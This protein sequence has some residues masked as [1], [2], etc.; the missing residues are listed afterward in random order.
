MAQVS[1]LISSSHSFSPIFSTSNLKHQTRHPCMAFP[2]HLQYPTNFGNSDVFYKFS[3]KNFRLQV[4]GGHLANKLA[5]KFSAS[6]NSFEK[7]EEEKAVLPSSW[8]ESVVPLKAR[9]YAYLIRLDKPIGTWLVAWPCLWSLAFAAN[10]GTL[11]DLGMLAFFF[12][13]SFMTRNIGCTINDFF[14]KDFDAQVERTKRRPVAS[15][16]ITDSQALCFLAIQLLIGYVTFLP[17][18][19]LSRLLWVS[20]LPLIFTYPLMKRITYW[21]QAHLG[22]AINWGALYSWAAVKGSLD[23]TIVFPLF[24]AC[25]FWTLEYDTIYA[26]QD[27]EDDVKVGVKSTALLFGDSTKIW[28][29][30][31][32]VAS[33]SSLL[34]A[35]INS[36]I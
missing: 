12:L 28:T 27:K 18:N 13:V 14:D 32:G 8:I 17:I 25:F 1:N 20:S 35:G 2:I 6:A 3:I 26:H 9:P 29:T 16:T 31:F 19:E 22:L 23:E 11:P 21:P 24:T 36:N 30:G 33:V 7:V 34:V 5:P 15:G 4:R 10:P